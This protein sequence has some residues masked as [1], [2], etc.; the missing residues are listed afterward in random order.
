SITVLL[1]NLD[2]VLLLALGAVVA[3]AIVRLWAERRRRLAGSRLHVRF[4]VMFGIVAVTPAIIVALFSA[5]FL[6]LGIQAWFDKQVGTALGQSLVVA[7]AYLREHQQVV[8]GDVL[9]MANDIDR[10]GP[11]LLDHPEVL[12]RL[13]ATQAAIRSLPEALIITGSGRVL[14]RSGLTFSLELNG[15][16]RGALERAQQGEVV[17]IV[18]EDGD[19]V[20]ALVQL[21]RFIDTYLFV[22]RFVDAQVLGH[23]ARTRKAVAEYRRLE[24]Q[25][26]GIQITFSL[27]F[28]VVALMLLLAAVWLGLTFA[29]RLAQPLSRL[30][31]AAER[32]RAG[33]LMT[34]VPETA[35][36]DE[37]GSLA[38]SFNR[39]TSQLESQRRELIEANRQSETR[40]R[41]TEVVLAGVSAG[42]IGLDQAGRVH[43]P[44]RSASDL[45]GIDLTG[46]IGR[47]LGDVVPEMAPSLAAARSQ[48]DRLYESQIEL[49]RAGATRTLLVRVAVE[50]EGGDIKGFVVTFD[51]VTELLSAQRKAA[52]G[53]VARRI[54]HEIKNPLTPIQLSAERLKR[55]YLD[56]IGGDRETFETCTDTIVRQV[57]TI[58]RMVDEFS[59]FARMP[60]PVV[61]PTDLTEIGK[62]SLFL[63]RNAHTDIRFEGVYPGGPVWVECD[64]RQVAQAVTNLL[65]NA[66]EA[67]EGRPAPADGAPPLPKGRVRL[68][69]TVD[70]ETATVAVEDNG[71]GLPE[72]GRARLTEP[73]VTT[74]DKGTGLGLAIVKK[75]ME[76]HDGELRLEDLENGP[77]TRARLI[78]PIPAAAPNRGTS[79][80]AAGVA[81]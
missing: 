35:E 31:T 49:P 46:T 53:D 50:H 39:M 26:S 61:K 8:R 14:A 55:K 4:V 28:V 18:G 54:A 22:G 24:G 10:E 12:S 56:R 76:D 60:A 6:N 37:I 48:P 77:G 43:L 67:I 16:P 13:V 2:L 15:L 74:R 78:F 63:E 34:R 11:R 7:E 52:W 57:G 45:L 17:V 62:Q 59:A 65:K 20:R 40:R 27:I 73:Y 23:I 21:Q 3:R 64:G 68:V 70:S 81:E 36:E 42:V 9:A 1:L 72:G 32:V 33:D 5:L 58:G 19:R 29:N 79:P 25:R 80:P 47:P 41:F 44:N 30:V 51:D 71:K 66:V 38:R 75:I 69:V